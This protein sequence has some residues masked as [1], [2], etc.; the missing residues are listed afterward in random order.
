MANKWLIAIA[1]NFYIFFSYTALFSIT[2][3]YLL[4]QITYLGLIK[5]SLILFYGRSGGS[6]ILWVQYSFILAQEAPFSF[7]MIIVNDGVGHIFSC[8]VSAI[9][10]HRETGLWTSGP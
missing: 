5:Y 1:Q 6:P 10:F 2:V 3:P 9:Q 7:P 8:K 4:R